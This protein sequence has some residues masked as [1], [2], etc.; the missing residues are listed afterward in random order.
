ML[1]MLVIA[2][3]LLVSTAAFAQ[4]VQTV[5]IDGK[6]CTIISYN[7]GAQTFVNCTP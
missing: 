1:K 3:A 4:N 7:N 5:F 2:A 6:I